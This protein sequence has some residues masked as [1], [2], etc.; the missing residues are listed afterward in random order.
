MSANEMAK[1]I[2][3]HDW[4]GDFNAP[5]ITFVLEMIRKLDEACLP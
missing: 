5:E 1:W 3:E 2:K 4:A